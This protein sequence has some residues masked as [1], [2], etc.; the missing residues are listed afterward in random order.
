MR[1]LVLIALVML[2]MGCEVPVGGDKDDN[3]EQKRERPADI[4]DVMDPLF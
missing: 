4:N 1:W 3:E 2:A